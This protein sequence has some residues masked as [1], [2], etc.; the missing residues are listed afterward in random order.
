[1]LGIN[2]RPSG[3]QVRPV[4]YFPSARSW[5][6]LPW[7]SKSELNETRATS[8]NR[9]SHGPWQEATASERPVKANAGYEYDQPESGVRKGRGSPPCTGSRN[10]APAPGAGFSA[11]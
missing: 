6:G 8:Q 5:R 7:G 3:V 1:V 9:K 11:G 4:I 10:S 2:E